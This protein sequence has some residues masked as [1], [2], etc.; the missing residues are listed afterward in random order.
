MWIDHLG[1][2]GGLD[3]GAVNLVDPKYGLLWIRQN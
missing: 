1:Q 3:V 2:P